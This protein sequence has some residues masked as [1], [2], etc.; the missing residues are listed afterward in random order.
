MDEDNYIYLEQLNNLVNNIITKLKFID[1]F[2]LL[3]IANNTLTNIFNDMIKIINDMK[4]NGY[5]MDN[6]INIVSQSVI[7]TIYTIHNIRYYFI[8]N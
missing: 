5:P 8:N 3:E 2:E 1:T 7:I 4:N 6:W